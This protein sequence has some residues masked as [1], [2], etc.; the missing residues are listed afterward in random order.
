MI[1]VGVVGHVDVDPAVVVEVLADD[2]ETR[3]GHRGD[4]RRH[5]DVGE[6]AVAAVVQ[7]HVGDGPKDLRTAIVGQARAVEAAATG[8]EGHV[9]GDEEVQQAVTVVVEKGRRAGPARH[10]DERGSSD[11]LERTVTAVAI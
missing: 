4:T 10:V 1:R 9:A 5:A 2:A 7:Q 3:G 11:V 6:R 8:V